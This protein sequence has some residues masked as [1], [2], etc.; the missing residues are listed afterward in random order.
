MSSLATTTTTTTT[1]ESDEPATES[2]AAAF[3]AILNTRASAL[4][5]RSTGADLDAASEADLCNMINELQAKRGRC[6]K[7]WDQSLKIF[8]RARDTGGDDKSPVEEADCVQYLAD[9]YTLTKEMIG[10][11]TW[12]SSEVKRIESAL[13][14][15]SSDVTARAVM[16]IQTLEKERLELAVRR[17]K[18]LRDGGDDDTAERLGELVEEL[19]DLTDELKE[20]ISEP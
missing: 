11:F 2:D 8:C 7:A 13:E 9:Y 10:A 20:N 3:F 17:H 4:E 14:K 19:R 6:Y 15:R 12:A 1:T 5:Q 18:V 16:N